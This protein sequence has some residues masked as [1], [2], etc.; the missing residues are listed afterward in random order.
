MCMCDDT[1]ENTSHPSKFQS[2]RSNFYGDCLGRDQD[3]AESS[4]VK[5]AAVA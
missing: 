1:L 3:V 5:F 4:Q 2:A